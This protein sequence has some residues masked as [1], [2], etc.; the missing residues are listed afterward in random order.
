MKRFTRNLSYFTTAFLVT[1]VV[2]ILTACGS[3]VG[4]EGAEDGG[5]QGPKAPKPVVTQPR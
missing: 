2:V 4:E 1:A 3:G 5:K